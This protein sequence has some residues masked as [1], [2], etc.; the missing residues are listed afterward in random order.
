MKHIGLHP[1]KCQNV[2]RFGKASTSYWQ[3]YIWYWYLRLIKSQKNKQIKSLSNDLLFLLD[4]ILHQFLLLLL[5][6]VWLLW[7]FLDVFKALLSQLPVFVVKWLLWSDLEFPSSKVETSMESLRRSIILN[8]M[9]IQQQQKHKQN[10]HST[11]TK[12]Q[13]KCSINNNKNTDGGLK[14]IGGDRKCRIRTMWSSGGHNSARV[15]GNL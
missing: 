8:K 3:L 14:H 7:L 4:F 11:T 6:F 12:T 1:W 10:I 2:H 15:L 5:F 9:F 13:K